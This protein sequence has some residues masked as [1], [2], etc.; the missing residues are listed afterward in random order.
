MVAH[1]EVCPVVGRTGV[2]ACAGRVS[3][4]TWETA[5]DQNDW[6]VI[7]SSTPFADGECWASRA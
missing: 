3:N 4:L 5:S 6:K 2:A 1:F 7:S